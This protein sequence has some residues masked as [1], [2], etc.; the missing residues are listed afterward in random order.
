[1]MLQTTSSCS[2]QMECD[3][4]EKHA[5]RRVSTNGYISYYPG[6]DEYV[7]G[8]LWTKD[9]I[10]IND[11]QEKMLKFI[12]ERGYINIFDN[13]ESL[14]PLMEANK[15]YELYEYAYQEYE[16]LYY[17]NKYGMQ[18]IL[19]F[20]TEI[21]FDFDGDM[22]TRTR[23]NQDVWGWVDKKAY[24]DSICDTSTGLAKTC[25]NC[26]YAYR[27]TEENGKF[28]IQQSQG[29]YNIYDLDPDYKYINP[30]NF[31]YVEESI[32]YNV[33]LNTLQMVKK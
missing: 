5:H 11:R 13:E 27:I 33:D 7:S 31:S 19:P 14:K 32:P 12:G 28:T 22:Q 29:A 23:I 30:N 15:P 2:K 21:Y 20:E 8:Y 6:E 17:L 10:L 4:K 18:T 3:I 26:Y 25:I 24:S 9:T 16:H 1:M